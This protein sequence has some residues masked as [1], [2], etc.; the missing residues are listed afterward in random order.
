V[1][2]GATDQNL[3]VFL[4]KQPVAPLL[5]PGAGWTT[6]C[7]GR[8][9][10]CPLVHWITKFDVFLEKLARAKGDESGRLVLDFPKTAA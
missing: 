4:E 2:S 8:L 7:N 5:K 6:V 9:I 10:V 1:S 3:D